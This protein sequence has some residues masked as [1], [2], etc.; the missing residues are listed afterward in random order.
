MK[1]RLL[2]AGL[3]LVAFIAGLAW[4]QDSSYSAENRKKGSQSIELSPGGF[5]PLFVLDSAFSFYSC[6]NMNPGAVFGIQY[7]YMLSRH[8]AVGGSIS[9]SF[10]TTIG[11][12][13]LFLAPICASASWLGGSDLLEFDATLE[14][15]MNIMRL[16]G[17]GMIS[18]IVKA[19]AGL[20]RYISDAWSIG[21]RFSWWFVPELHTGTYTNLNSYANFLEFGVSARYHF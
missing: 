2:A 17:S 4:A 14:T 20:S 16:S 18:P 19:G 3:M 13:T 5:V 11:G 6:S 1:R 21:G 10:V 7:R 15:G 12:R 8:L 9:G